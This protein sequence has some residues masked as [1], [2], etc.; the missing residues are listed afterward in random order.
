VDNGMED[1]THS[2]VG[3]TDTFDS[4]EAFR[5]FFYLNSPVSLVF[6]CKL[7]SVCRTQLQLWHIYRLMSVELMDDLPSQVL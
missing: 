3:S 5:G 1:N 7:L 4:Q 2:T 6:S